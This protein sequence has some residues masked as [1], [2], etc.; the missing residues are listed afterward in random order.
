MKFQQKSSVS[1]NQVKKKMEEE[2]G[3]AP[4][5]LCLP[6]FTFLHSFLADCPLYTNTNGLHQWEEMGT[7]YFS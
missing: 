5:T 2:K 7:V 1:F 4:L 3:N 6:D